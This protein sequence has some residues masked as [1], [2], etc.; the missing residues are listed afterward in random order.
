MN[1]KHF[2]RTLLLFILAPFAE[3]ILYYPYAVTLA[4]RQP[5]GTFL[6]FTPIE[7]FFYNFYWSFGTTQFTVLLQTYFLYVNIYAIIVIP[8]FFVLF[9]ILLQQLDS[10]FPQRRFLKWA[11][12]LF[13]AAGIHW[14]VFAVVYNMVGSPTLWE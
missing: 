11:I 5:P 13:V 3:V 14:L 10:R 2:G 1:W 12:A 8:L 9:W 4:F 7:Q 6:D